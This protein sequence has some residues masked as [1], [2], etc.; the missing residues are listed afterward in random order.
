[1]IEFYKNLSQS[2]KRTLLIAGI[3]LSILLFYAVVWSPLSSS[4]I[5]LRTDAQEQRELLSWM[6]VAANE[7]KTLKASQRNRKGNSHGNQ[8]L[9]AMVDQTAKRGKLGPALRRVEPKGRNEVRVKLEDAVFDDLL[10]WLSQLQGSYQVDVES[11]S[12][13]RQDQPGRV[14]ANITL[15]GTSP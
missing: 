6:N 11:I 13:D 3:A 12:I 15:K 4:I 10:T 9:L 14:N 7:A 5:T 2:E 1:M 8:S